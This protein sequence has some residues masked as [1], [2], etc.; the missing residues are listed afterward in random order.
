MKAVRNLRKRLSSV[1]TQSSALL[2]ACPNSVTD[3]RD[4]KGEGSSSPSVIQH[5]TF[6]VKPGGYSTVVI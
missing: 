6:P 2:N 5:D 3:L 4:G 1:L